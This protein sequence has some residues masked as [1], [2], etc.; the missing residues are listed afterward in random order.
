MKKITLIAL[1]LL[2]LLGCTSV[3]DDVYTAACDPNETLTV[4]SQQGT[5][6]VIRD[7]IHQ[8]PRD[9]MIS[10][11]TQESNNNCNQPN[12]HCSWGY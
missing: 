1:T 2:T 7:V 3:H 10:K 9:C 5:G 11:Q 6:L 8:E 12:R 4:F